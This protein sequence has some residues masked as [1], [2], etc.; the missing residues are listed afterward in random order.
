MP[1]TLG[2]YDRQDIPFYYA[3][4][5][6]FTVCDQ[7]FCSSLTATTPN[8]LHLWT[9][10]IREQQSAAAMPCVRNADVDY[11]S[12]VRW[13]TFPERLEDAGVSWKIYQN[14]LSLEYR[15]HQRG[16][17]MA[18][19]L[20]RQPDRVVRAI[21][22]WILGDLSPPSG[23]PAPRRSPRKSSSFATVPCRPMRPKPRKRSKNLAAREA[24]LRKVICRA[25][26]MD[27]GGARQAVAARA[28]P[29][30]QSLHDQC[31]R[32]C[33]PATLDAALSRRRSEPRDGDSQGRRAAPVP[34]GRRDRAT[35]RRLL[36]GARRRISPIIPSSAWYGA[37]YV[38]E[39]LNILTRNPEVWKKTIFV[40]TYDENDGY[41]DHVPPFVAPD[42]DNPETGKTSPGIDAGAGVSAPRAGPQAAPAAGSARRT[43]RA[44]LSRAA[45]RC[46]AMEPRRI[47]LLAGL[48]PHLRAAVLG[49]GAE[50]PLGQGDSRDQYQRV[51]QDGVRRSEHGIPALGSRER[52]IACRSPQ[53]TLSWKVSTRRSSSRMPSGYRKLSAADIEQFA[54]DRAAAP[55]DAAA[56]AGHSSIVRAALRASC[57]GRDQRGRQAFEIALEA[58]NE[59]FGEASAGAPF[60]VYTPGKF[61]GRIELRTRAY[62]VAAGQRLTDTWEIA[63]FEGGVYHLRVCG[64]NGFFREFAGTENDPPIDIRCRYLRTGDVELHV[65]SRMQAPC[66]LN[67]NGLS[68]TK[69]GITRCGSRR[70]PAARS[71]LR[72]GRSH[73]WYDFSV[74]VSGRESAT[75]AAM[76]AGSRPESPA[77]AIPPW[78]K[79]PNRHQ[80]I[81][82]TVRPA[83]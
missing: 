12:T 74:T 13:K 44:G 80:I 61:R 16:R 56:G 24:E 50:P 82:D 30:R 72:L 51:A 8:R 7:H 17:R 19:E 79:K 62:A 20:H 6:A 66:N 41:F 14:E 71:V 52:R 9:G 43:G 21:Q 33:I 48:R 49:E 42:P 63:G 4:A 25:P 68:H 70:A 37:W 57:G 1:L 76:R 45:G 38:A 31:R 27:A 47:R 78:R 75:S 11:D 34:Q 29:A 46:V 64:P 5:D 83:K 69:A 18:G 59:T 32:P 22:R 77:S 40:L 39:A 15:I 65:S 23:S 26:Q 3:L 60:H 2:Y 55:L 73:Q 81:V 10:T 53:E 36:A 54:R 67:V 28:Q 58:R 35:S